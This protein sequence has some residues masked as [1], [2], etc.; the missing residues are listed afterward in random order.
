MRQP[1]PPSP[2]QCK[3]TRAERGDP[4][5]QAMKVAISTV[6][7]DS[8]QACGPYWQYRDR[9]YVVGDKLLYDDQLVIPLPL[10]GRILDVLHAAHQ[11][12]SSMT[13]RA[14]QCVFWPGITKDIATRRGQCRTCDKISPSLPQVPTE[15]SEPPSTPF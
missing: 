11:G 4:A 7:A 12:V 13:H 8:V 6:G 15:Q 5:Y 1:R 3:V 14:S 10:R 2:S 9:M